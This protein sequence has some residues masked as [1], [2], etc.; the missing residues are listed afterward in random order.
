M[1]KKEKNKILEMIFCK[2]TC[3]Y[4]EAND[5]DFSVDDLI[6]L[7]FYKY[8]DNYKYIIEAPKLFKNIA[9]IEQMNDIHSFVY[10]ESIKLKTIIDYCNN[11]DKIHYVILNDTKDIILHSFES[12]FELCHH[13]SS[14]QYNGEIEI[15]C[16]DKNDINVIVAIFYL[17]TDSKLITGGGYS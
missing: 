9:S 2:S 4:L 3:N 12:F 13:I 16:I 8:S 10:N 14:T 17:D 5:F 7:Y 1:S 15:R 6:T 11:N